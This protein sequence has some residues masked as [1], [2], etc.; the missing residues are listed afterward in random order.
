MSTYYQFVNGERYDASLISNGQFRVKKAGDGRIS[1]QDAQDLWKIAMDG[2][3]MTEIEENTLH[4]LMDTLNWTEKAKSWMQE[5][6]S[7][8]VEKVTSY[9]KVIDGLRYDRKIMEEAERRIEGAGDGRISKD[10]AEFLWEMFGDFGDITIVEERTLAYLQK[11][12]KWTDAAS[13]FFQEKFGPISKQSSIEPLL[14]H[15]M[16]SEFGFEKL[17]L[18][19]FKSEAL[20]QMLDFKNAID[21]PG[22]LRA[23]LN[24]LLHDTTDR[25]LGALLS[26]YTDE[27]AKDFLEGGRLVLLPGDMASEPL[28]NSF[29]PPLDGEGLS[30]NWIFGL[31]LFDLSDDIYWVIVARDGKKAA[32]NYIGGANVED[33]WPRTIAEPYF[34]VRVESCG[35]GYPGITVEMQDPIGKFFVAKS[36]EEGY[37][38]VTGPKGTYSLYASDGWSFQSKSY[39]WGGEGSTDVKVL[40]LDC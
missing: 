34:S 6:L 38:K 16:K 4:Y 37:V 21:L 27:P 17:G 9:Y 26:G 25:S 20:Q 36:D 11:N 18:A 7:Q 15:I 19:Y 3:R 13:T 10:D 12:L 2:G 24:S 14:L 1:L 35:E 32:Y 33:E 8:A 5:E 39:D 29:P 31:E 30:E 22:A 28:L 40:T 23:A